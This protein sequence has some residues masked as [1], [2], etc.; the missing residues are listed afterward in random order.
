[1]TRRLRRPI[2]HAREIESR[3]STCAGGERPTHTDVKD[4]A[5]LE[6]SLEL[7][8][9]GDGAMLRDQ[10]LSRLA[11]ELGVSI[12]VREG[13]KRRWARMDLLG[14]DDILYLIHEANAAGDRDEMIWRAFLA[15]HFGRAS[16][17]PGQPDSTA[18]LLCGAGLAPMWTWAA[19]S[20]APDAFR[21]W[22]VSQRAALA[23]LRF[24][25]H[26]KYESKEPNA[27]W[28]VIQSFLVVVSQNG[29]S[30]ALAFSVGWAARRSAGQRFHDLYQLLR[31]LH[32]FGRLG[33]FDFV[34]LLAQ[35]GLVDAAPD[36]CYLVG[37][38]GPL[39]GAKQLWRGRS[40]QELEDLAASLA[41]RLNVSPAVIEDTLC[42]W[43]K[44]DRPQR[45]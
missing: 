8:L 14:N 41:R 27:L 17:A 40:D 9:R 12:R 28:Q 29:D 37:S 34:M 32:R 24:G 33:A 16:Q 22:L 5:A 39:E 43:Q 21:D 20:R 19:V 15:A 7:A 6:A 1:M 30:P 36:S 45:R 23:K 3:A 44:R 11:Q 2:C 31:G 13:V 35:L 38:T 18:W 10:E 26:R 42:N 4:L 25:N